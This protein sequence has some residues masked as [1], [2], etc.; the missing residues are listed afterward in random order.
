MA[1]L[2]QPVDYDKS[3]RDISFY[4]HLIERLRN[5]SCSLKTNTKLATH[6]YLKAAK[7]GKLSLAQRRAF[8][9]EQYSIQYSDACS[10]AVLAG[11]TN[12][13]PRS[14]SVA[15]PP[16]S[17]TESEKS[18]PDIFQFLLGGEIYASKLLLD[19]AKSVGLDS[20]DEGDLR[21]Y[22]VTAKAQAYPSYWARIALT[23]NRG[24]GAAVS[25]HI[26]RIRN[27]HSFWIPI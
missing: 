26:I 18:Q 2:N 11:H 13:R 15:S 27:W 16:T 10:F 23:G 21:R 6:P 14:L 4:L 5:E 20:E 25:D 8:V 24:A 22:P 12:F 3:T 7:E 9:G 1:S 17:I 19:H